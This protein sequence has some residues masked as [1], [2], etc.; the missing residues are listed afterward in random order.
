M[1]AEP[2]H[3]L[4]KCLCC[5]DWVGYIQTLVLPSFSLYLSDTHTQTH[6]HFYS[7][8][9]WS[10]EDFCS[11]SPMSV[12]LDSPLTSSRLPHTDPP[13][14]CLYFTPRT[15]QLDRGRAFLQVQT[16]HVKRWHIFWRN[17]AKGRKRQFRERKHKQRW[18]NMMVASGRQRKVGERKRKN[19]LHKPFEWQPGDLRHETYTLF[20][21]PECK[22]MDFVLLI[23]QLVLRSKWVYIR[24]LSRIWY[25]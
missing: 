9:G 10:K 1:A 21:E 16:Y 13:S 19:C 7:Q 20:R 18:S 5:E 23:P 15:Q 24:F 11:F 12:S 6:T 2:D 8:H 22:R 14:P 17:W 3:L 25:F 4:W